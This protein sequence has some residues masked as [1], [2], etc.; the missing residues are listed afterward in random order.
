MISVEEA[1]KIIRENVQAASPI[2]MPLAQASNHVLAEDVYAG[3][4]MPGFAQSAMD[5]YAFRFEDY[6]NH[7]PI[8][9]NGEMAA[10][11]YSAEGIQ[12]NTAVRIFTGAP[13]P[14]N[15]D[16][17]V[18]QEK[19][20][21]EE[22]NQLIINDDAILLGANVRPLGSEIAKNELALPKGT[23]LSPA[24]IGFLA[25]LGIATVKVLPQPII[26][27]IVTGN[28]LQ[29]PG[30]TLLP[31]HVYESNSI[32]LAAALQQLHF[33]LAETYFIRDDLS[34]LTTALNKSLQ[35]ADI[36]LLTGGVSAGDYDFVTMAAQACGVNQLFHKIKQKPGKPMFFG[37]YNNKLVFGLPGNPSSVLTCFYEYV[38]DALMQYC[39]IQTR[40]ATMYLPLAN[41]FSKKSGLTHFLKGRIVN[42][43]AVPLTAQES[44][45]LSSFAIADC[46]II[47]EEN[48]TFF[49][50]GD[51]VEVHLLP[52]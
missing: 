24:A 27:L 34:V 48:N 43:E 4:N 45:R 21:I 15:T 11:S 5:G 17:V 38:L 2:I 6:F 8:F 37:R 20:C 50:R 28:E 1:R 22:N 40:Q 3:I 32:M 14:P 7:Q 42:N 25:S 52:E 30:T 41:N 10:G 51:N 33:T 13:V 49:N 39:G 47:L 46:L 44:Y 18:M 31:G 19:V 12:P 16:T 23:R 26:H 35:V 36:V 9:V 29:V